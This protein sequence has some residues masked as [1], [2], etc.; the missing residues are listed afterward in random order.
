MPEQQLTW[1][2]IKQR[3]HEEWVELT[4]YDWPDGIPWPRS[5]VVRVHSP[6]RKEFWRLANEK[7]PPVTDSAVVFVG[8]PDKPGIIRNNLMTI[9]VCEK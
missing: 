7:M 8:P 1:E 5:G 4:N 3:Y 2:Q 9:T 6:N